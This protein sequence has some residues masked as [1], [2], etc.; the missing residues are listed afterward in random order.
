MD[1]QCENILWFLWFIHK[2]VV[3]KPVYSKENIIIEKT[4]QKTNY[5]LHVFVIFLE[6]LHV[7]M[8]YVMSIRGSIQFN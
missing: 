5:D 4:L 6:P 2:W 3:E 7:H 1:I 8:Y